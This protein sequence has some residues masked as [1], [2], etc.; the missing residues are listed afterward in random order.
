MQTVDL[1]PERLQAH[2]ARIQQQIE[3]NRA[4]LHSVQQRIAVQHNNMGVHVDG[5]VHF[6][7]MHPGGNLPPH[8]VAFGLTPQQ[9][10]QF[11]PPAFRGHQTV[12]NT[13][14]I[15]PNAATNVTTTIQQTR[16]GFRTIIR[17]NGEQRIEAI[18]STPTTVSQEPPPSNPS[19]AN[20]PQTQAGS[21][22][23]PNL[24]GHLPQPFNQNRTSADRSVPSEGT[25]YVLM[26]STGPQGLLFAPGFGWFSSG[27]G[28]SQQPAVN[29]STTPPGGTAQTEDVMQQQPLGHVDGANANVNGAIIR[30]DQRPARP[31]VAQALQ[32]NAE[33]NDF[34]AVLI[35][36]VWLFLR[37]YLFMFVFSEPG[38]WKRWAMIFIAIV[39]CLQPRDGPIVRAVRAARLHLDN[40]IGPQAPPPQP[41]AV[42][43]RQGGPAEATNPT[44]PR[45]ANIRGAV[46]MT[47]E[48]AAARLL[49]ESQERNRGFWRESL[50]RI[51]HGMALFLA[52]LI[53][54]VGERHVLAREE[55]RRQ[56]QR[57]EEERRRAEEA[58]AAAATAATAEPA[59]GQTSAEHGQ[60][61]RVVT[62]T[63]LEAQ[64]E[65]KVD[66]PDGSS[67]S[68]S[69]QIRD[70]GVEDGELRNRTT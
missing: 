5:P 11:R 27:R 40:L 1:D 66:R 68:S 15:A 52:S 64:A 33:D 53:P 41:D 4:D 48:E 38:T 54:G 58:A 19:S 35:R 24:L 63:S 45:P 61:G 59:A 25:A 47:P 29:A 17:P 42:A 37:L 13:W 26:T 20:A 12:P 6:P 55:E 18:D 49:R 31:Q 9:I 62:E 57:E 51:E 60:N 43:P 44:P 50:Y 65:A 16:T 28:A 56:A 22:P 46:Q 70:A 39:V 32:N 34:F 10:A 14:T 30:P 69:V 8:P 7:A 3:A 36:R 21:L 67:S 2:L 23:L